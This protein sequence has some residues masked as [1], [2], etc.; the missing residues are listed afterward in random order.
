MLV[1]CGIAFLAVQ[2]TTYSFDVFL[3]QLLDTYRYDVL[4]SLSNPQSYVS[5]QKVLAT[6][7][8]IRQTEPLEQY[9]VDTKWG[10]GILTGVEPATQLYQKYMIAGRWFT[11]HDSNVV[12]LS[13]DAANKAHLN[14]GDSIAL[15][16]STV[17]AKW[18]IIGIARD[19]GGINPGQFGVLLAP[20][21][22]VNAYTKQPVCYTQSVMVQTASST[23]AET[24]TVTRRLDDAMS[25]A[26]IQ[27]T[28]TTALQE[29]Q[30]TQSES[31]IL[32]ILLYVVTCIVALVSGMG[33]FNA[34]AMSVLERRREIGILR[35]LGATS[36]KVAEVF[37]IEGVALSGIAWCIATVLGIPAAYGFVVLLNR[38]LFPVP[39]AFNP[40]SLLIM[41]GFVLLVTFLASGGPVL[42]AMRVKIVQTLRYE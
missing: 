19:Y 22:Q 16:G 30:R 33:L 37:W 20:I 28:V 21:R 35:S 40:F 31:Q 7:P 2:T 10:L 5:L 41:L 42:G 17:K 3:S 9:G 39:F 24:N 23:L 27:A 8:E 4:V 14:V 13:Q 18:R 38:L 25:H 15:G 26:A 11:V 36:R 29:K 34:L 6:V 12:V 32:A 1:M